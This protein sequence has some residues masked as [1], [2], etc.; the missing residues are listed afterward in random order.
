MPVQTIGREKRQ[1]KRAAKR[2]RLF[3]RNSFLRRRTT[4]VLGGRDR[5]VGYLAC[6]GFRVAARQRKLVI[7]ITG[8]PPGRMQLVPGTFAERRRGGYRLDVNAAVS[9]VAIEL[10]AHGG[11]R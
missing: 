7:Q 9:Q 3:G 11:A 2:S 1:F 10:L 6:L 4:G 5:P 8:L